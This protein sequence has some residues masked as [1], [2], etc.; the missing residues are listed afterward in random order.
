MTPS[1]LPEWLT[2]PSILPVRC[3]EF[4]YSPKVSK[5]ICE[6][7]VIAPGHPLLDSDQ[8][9]VDSFSCLITTPEALR[10]TDLCGFVHRQ[11]TS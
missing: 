9:R 10:I 1:P 2:T 7:P 5:R 8:R 4:S 11:D 3:Q 6:N